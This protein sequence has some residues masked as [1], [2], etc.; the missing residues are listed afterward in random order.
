MDALFT[1]IFWLLVIACITLGILAAFRFFTLRSRGTSV[2]MRKM[3]AKDS[4]SWR[5]GMLRYIGESVKFFK[6]RSVSPAADLVFNRL[7]VELLGTRKLDDDE[8]SFM[9]EAAEVLHFRAGDRE[10]EVA[11]DL[12]GIL[13]LIAWI[14]SAPSRRQE[15]QDFER[16]RSRAT[17]YPKH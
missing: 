15:K 17:R 11:S 12:H 9:P 6:L 10:Y 16:L 7:D 2:L 14:E 3:P 13:A 8:A 1:V 4:H 5:H